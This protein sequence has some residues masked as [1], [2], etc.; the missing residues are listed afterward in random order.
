MAVEIYDNEAATLWRMAPLPDLDLAL[1][2]ES[3]ALERDTEGLP[4]A[5]RHRLQTQHRHVFGLVQ[6]F[7]V[8]DDQNTEYRPAGG[9]GSGG[10]NEATG[11]LLVRPA[12]PPRATMLLVDAMGHQLRIPL[13]PDLKPYQGPT[14]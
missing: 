5:D 10:S 6:H 12:P 4:E 14:A 3:A 7:V 11:R 8:K 2:E 13:Q 9:G 1:P